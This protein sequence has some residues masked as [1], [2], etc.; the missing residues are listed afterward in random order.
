[1]YHLY[2]FKTSGN[3][4]KV[5]LLLTQLGLPFQYHEC[6]ILKGAS[7]TMDFLKMNP[8]GKIPVLIT[9]EGKSLSESNAILC[10][11]AEGTD[12]LPSDRWS[13]AEVLRWLFWE[14]YSHEPF[15]ATSRF[16]MH[17]CNPDDFRDKIADR[18]QGGEHALGLMESHLKGRTFFVD[19]TY[20]IADI[21]LYAYTH[22]S[23]EG[24]FALDDYPAIRKWLALVASQPGYL[25]IYDPAGIQ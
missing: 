23:H 3:G 7:R 11:L 21:A 20:T 16:W 18:R 2:D 14:Q 25:G 8:N 19:E 17:L 9:P 6:D 5:R 22:V 15:I 24:G 1:M 13:K 4:F 10:Y 12:F